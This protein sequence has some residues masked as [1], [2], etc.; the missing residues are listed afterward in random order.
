MMLLR[1]IAMIS[2]VLAFSPLSAHGGG[3]DHCGGHHDRKNGGYHVH[4][5]AQYCAC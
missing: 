4:N 5:Q 3:L 1:A 2:I